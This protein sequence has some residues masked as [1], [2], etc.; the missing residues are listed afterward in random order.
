Q[1][2]SVKYNLSPLREEEIAE[3]VNFRLKKAGQADVKILPQSYKIIYQFSKGIPR[4]INI[5]CDRALLFGFAKE[6]KVLD[7]E[8]FKVCVEELI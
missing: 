5:L 6:K 3:Y 7:E 2:I 4:L 1:R 8:V